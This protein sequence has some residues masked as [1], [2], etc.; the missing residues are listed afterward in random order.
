MIR[1]TFRRLSAIAATSA[2]LVAHAHAGSF[3]GP[4]SSQSP[5]VTPTLPAVDV[6]SI[7]TVG[8]S[9]GNYAMVGI[10]D[11]LGAYDNGNGTFTVLMNHELGPAVGAVRAHGS[12]G[13]FVSEWVI[14][15]ADFSV[16]SGQ[17]LATSHLVWDA[18]TSGFVP[19]AGAANA[20]GRLCSSDLPAVSA[21]YNA[22]SGLGTQSRILLNG[23][24]VGAEGRGYGFVATGADKGKAYELP[25]LGRFSW[26][27][28]LANPFSG[29]KTIVIG[30]DDSTPGQVYVYNGTKTSTGTEVDRAGLNN[31]ALFGIKTS[32]AVE[33]APVTGAFTLE[34]VTVP[35]SGATLQTQ[36]NA[37][38]ITNFARPEDGHWADADTFYFVTTGADPD[39]AGAI[40][41]QSAKL[42]RLDFAADYSAGQ[43]SLVLDAPTVIGTDGQAAR[44]FDNMV[45]ADDG[46]ILIQEDPGNTPYIAKTR[47]YDPIANSTR[48]LLESDR[49]RFLD[50]VTETPVN[51]APPGWLTNDEESSGVIDITAILNRNDGRRYF[52][53]DMQAH[54]P[55][56]PTLVEGG[57]LYAISVAVPEPA[58]FGL[59]GLAACGLALA[60]RRRTSAAG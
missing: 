10:P 5:Y 48:Q 44:S 53:G 21:F 40:G 7:L 29:D 22:S 43:I 6:T 26:E 25:L 51:V 52:L 27:N 33:A 41:F 16:V 45:V 54:Y 12:V 49:G 17:D 50:P 58:T 55:N 24:E 28:A 13:S 57:Q 8:D 4:S 11:G 46:K 19:A 31:G 35:Q 60:A 34:A 20:F 30:L 2:T 42:Y 38:G 59:A 14:N 56:G 3:T 18:L 36:S 9:V 37:L 15:K 23:E 1:R 32:Q 47:E 39:G